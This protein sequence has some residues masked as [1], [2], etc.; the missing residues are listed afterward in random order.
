MTSVKV[1]AVCPACGR[2]ASSPGR[3]ECLY[4][5][6]P[7]T[8]VVTGT[9]SAAGSGKPVTVAPE[10]LRSPGP[11]SLATPVPPPAAKPAWMRYEAEER[12]VARFFES[13][14]VRFFLV[15]A[16]VLAGILAIAKL[17]DDHRPPGF[18]QDPV[19]R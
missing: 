17:I 18:V 19:E 9:V 8:A 7:L 2:P 12:P 14:W 6:A 1:R 5:G 10:N 13:G 11:V 16:F 3:S 15:V 4:C